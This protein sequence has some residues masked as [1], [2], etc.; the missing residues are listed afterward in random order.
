MQGRQ[1]KPSSN[2]F[3]GSS[4]RPI[5]VSGVVGG[6]FGKIYLGM[7]KEAL[8]RHST[9][10]THFKRSRTSETLFKGFQSG[11]AFQRF[12][13]NPGSSLFHFF[14]NFRATVNPPLATI[15]ARQ[16]D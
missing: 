14:S 5:S 4:S 11:V 3:G 15:F 10:E 1:S 12:L 8:A 13:L 16:V 2:R 9:P 6:T 7:G